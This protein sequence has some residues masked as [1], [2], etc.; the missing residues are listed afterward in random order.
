MRLP[1]RTPRTGGLRT[2]RTRGS[3]GALVPA[4][5]AGPLLVGLGLAGCSDGGVDRSA[6]PTPSPF[7]TLTGPPLTI[8]APGGAGTL[9]STGADQDAE[10][11]RTSG[12]GME[13][14]FGRVQATAGRAVVAVAAGGRHS[15]AVL[16]DGTVLSWGAD[17]S[18]QLGRGGSPDVAAP[19]QAPDG[20]SGVLH[21]VVAVAADTN[22]S[23]ALR[24]D[25]T[26][27]SWGS[28]DAGQRGIGPGPAPSGPTEVLAA[29]GRP[30]THVVQI[31]AD[32]RTELALLSDGTAVSWGANTYGMLGD[33]TRDD[34]A[35]PVHVKSPSGTRTLGG[36]RQIAL[37]G[38]HGVAALVTGEL[39]TW[40]RNDLGQ[41][42]DGSR[43]DRTLPG[44]VKG[45]HGEPVL[46]DVVQVSA[47]EKHMYARRSD[48]TVAAWGNNSAGQL[49][50]GSTEE[51]DAP[52]LVVNSGT[53]TPLAGVREVV[54]GEAYGVAVLDDGSARTW[55]ANGHG[56]LGDGDRAPRP[57]PGLV[58]GT[59]GT[60]F[61]HVLAVGAGERHLLLLVGR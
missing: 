47:A 31:A 39:L 35:Y 48:G 8:P 40:G 17:D 3:H 57:V 11:G 23:M 26:V 38:Q 20:A 10:L 14:E 6:A 33:G 49:G 21:G 4:L 50:D 12:Q 53:G 42:G 9:W 41:L 2:L 15:L 16:A 22:F 19:V 5:V 27:V 13:V 18:G 24:S 45:L 56:Q 55:G 1:R 30:L 46:T 34:R 25:G 36:I 37:G 58:V 61:R 43:Q 29:K 28:G 60:L 7:E 32:G 51:R 44:P 54:A 52:V 59:G